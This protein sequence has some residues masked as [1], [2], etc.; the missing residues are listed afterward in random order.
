[1]RDDIDGLLL[2]AVKFIVTQ[3][4]SKRPAHKYAHNTILPQNDI[5]TNNTGMQRLVAARSHDA[6]V[7]RFSALINLA[8]ED[9]EKQQLLPKLTV[10]PHDMKDS[11]LS[12]TLA[13]MLSL[14]KIGRAS[15]RAGVCQ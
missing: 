1:M 4:N 3:P 5:D 14:F 10:H 12:K 11:S 9:L 7:I 6:M 13:E 2:Q 15:C 8:A